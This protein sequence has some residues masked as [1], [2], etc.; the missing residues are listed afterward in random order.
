MKLSPLYLALSAA[1]LPFCASAQDNTSSNV[2][3]LDPIVVT[4]SRVAE[5]LSNVVGDVS[6]ISNEQLQRETSPSLVNILARTPGIQ[7]YDNG[8]PQTV[9]GIYTRGAN[10]S[11][12]LVLVNGLRIND[13]L[14]GGVSWSTLNPAIFDHIEIIRGSASGL[15]GSSAMGGVINLITTPTQAGPRDLKFTAN[16]GGGSH[17]T[18]R[19]NASIS[20]AT[21]KFDYFLAG[22]YVTSD[23]SNATN[24]KAGQFTYNKDK[25]GFEQA[26][27]IGSLGYR[28][29]PGQH[30]GVTFL[31]AYNH[32]D[33]DAGA[34]LSNAYTLSRQ[35]A[36]AITSTNEITPW[37]TSTL[38]FGF[39]K[40]STYTP[41]Y[42][43]KARANARQYSWQNDFKIT[44]G[45][46]I[47]LLYEHTKDFLDYSS[48][49]D[50]KSRHAN[51]IAALY[52]GDFGR[53]HVQ[54]NIRRDKISGIK[55][56]TTGGINYA[57]DL[58]P[59][60][61]VG[62]GFSTGFRAPTFTD[63]YSPFEQYYWNGFPSGSYQG[64]PHLR[65]EKSRNMEVSLRYHT[66]DTNLSVTAFQT[67]YKDLIDGYVCDKL[68]TCTA[69]NVEKATIRGITLEASHRFGNT[70]I[71][72]GADFLNPKNKSDDTPL[73]GNTLPRRA[74]QVYRASIQHDFERLS[75]GM[76]YLFVGKR[77][78]DEENTKA[79]RLGGYG[80]VNLRAD[81]AASKNF[82]I[83]ASVNNVFN[84]K[85]EPVYGYN[86]RGTNFFLNLSY[87]H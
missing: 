16:L 21:E 30:I 3:T 62:A 50:K 6:V 22:S 85:Y 60:L 23:G 7:T 71:T 27:I 77:E 20:G 73:K 48:G 15:Y 44:E 5:P 72:A 42:A 45:Q 39:T 66:E 2:T 67:R 37:W 75:V 52:K 18:F 40:N 36:Y 4:A 49:L 13:S 65:P 82:H 57:F 12:T 74:K 51:A 78:S 56:H 25:D 55:G 46:T 17:G 9:S 63:M 87:Q 54:A 33:F 70:T 41:A 61:E 64:N 43:S 29:A 38:R 68:F 47:S 80:L 35:Q 81:Y 32:G 58:T 8:G 10:P 76:D 1:L 79:L 34:F 11:Q 86:G 31:N 53:H 19:T 83:Q 69:L 59:T 24:T 14:L 84:K 28:W 26:N